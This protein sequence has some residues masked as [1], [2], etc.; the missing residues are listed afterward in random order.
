MLPFGRPTFLRP[1]F[2]GQMRLFPS[3]I[4]SGSLTKDARRGK[5]AIY[6]VLA[7]ERCTLSLK[8]SRGRWVIDQLKCRSNQEPG[9]EVVEAVTQWLADETHFCW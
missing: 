7:P 4:D 2:R 5:I 3:S 9:A 8:L 6:R 1:H